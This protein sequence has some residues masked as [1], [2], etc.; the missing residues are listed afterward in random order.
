MDATSD[1]HGEHYLPGMGHDRLL[2]L[3]DPLCRL[4]GVSRAHE[5]LVVRA[6]IRPGH[7]VLEIGCGTGNLALL[8][9][10][11]HPGAE[12]VGLDPDPKALARA[13]RKAGRDGI[14]VS[15]D[16]GFAQEL[17]YPDASFDRVLS[18]FMF[19]HLGA[20][21]KAGALREARRV[22]KAGG[23]LHLLDVGGAKKRSDGFM[24][25]ISHRNR[26]LRDNFGDCI[27][28]LMREAGFADPTE[29]AQVDTRLMGRITYYRATAPHA[30][31]GADRH[32]SGPSKQT[33]PSAE[34]D[35]CR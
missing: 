32:G 16:P 24:A 23:S 11:L 25:R 5:S 14:S 6:G 13:R 15:L 9:K 8:A 7:R 34:S 3:Y 12:V 17:P 21:E 33:T 28:T 22:L 31:S 2:P 10:R 30:G 4:L 27:P 20:Q 18:A 29:V 26:M 1:G 35:A 19:H